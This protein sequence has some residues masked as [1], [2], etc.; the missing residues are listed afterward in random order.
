MPMS[1]QAKLLRAL[2]EKSVTPLGSQQNIPVDVRV[3][4][5]TIRD[6][7]AEIE[8]GNFR[9]DLFI[10]LMFFLLQQKIYAHALMI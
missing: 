4:A 9:E 6:M 1:L 5:T 10:G 2:Q 3:I 7:N 8:K